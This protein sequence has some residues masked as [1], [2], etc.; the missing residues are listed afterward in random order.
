MNARNNLDPCVAQA[1]PSSVG[2]L[3]VDASF[4]PVYINTEAAQVLTYPQLPAEIT[5]LD[6]Y[7]SEK[8]RLLFPEIAR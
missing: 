1:Y 5:A 6:R 8:V 3:L 7:L 2:F 4:N